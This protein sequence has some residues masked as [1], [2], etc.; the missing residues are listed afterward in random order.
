MSGKSRAMNVALI[1]RSCVRTRVCACCADIGRRHTHTLPNGDAH[2]HAAAA[3]YNH[4]GGLHVQ[5]QA[6]ICFAAAI[7]TACTVRLGNVYII[8]QGSRNRSTL[9]RTCAARK[10]LGLGFGI[11]SDTRSILSLCVPCTSK[12]PKQSTQTW[13]HGFAFVR[14]P[15]A[16]G[17]KHPRTPPVARCGVVEPPFTIECLRVQVC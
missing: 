17:S 13:Q 2:M 12:L 4:E 3:V 16:E 15:N 6:T 1:S 9:P 7:M 14:L 10:V 8:A 5:I 11:C